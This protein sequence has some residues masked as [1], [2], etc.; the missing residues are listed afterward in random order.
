MKKEW[1]AGKIC[2][3]EGCDRALSSMGMCWT[4]RRSAVE[5]ELRLA[6]AVSRKPADSAGAQPFQSVASCELCGEVDV[7][8]MPPA[9]PEERHAVAYAAV[10]VWQALHSVHCPGDVTV[11]VYAAEAAG[12]AWTLAGAAPFI[13][14]ERAGAD[15]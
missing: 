1:R 9:K 13:K 11:T 10:L 15:D 4:H 12:S 7:T 6:R 5:R 8:I 2:T 3:I 14:A